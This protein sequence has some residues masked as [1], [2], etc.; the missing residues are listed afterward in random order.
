MGHP[1]RFPGINWTTPII[2][3]CEVCGKVIKSVAYYYIHVK[4]CLLKKLPKNF[5]AQYQNKDGKVRCIGCKKTFTSIGCI[6]AKVLK[7]SIRVVVCCRADPIKFLLDFYPKG[8]CIKLV[9]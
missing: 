8:C 4:A 7:L 2:R 1:V 3:T 6:Y 5:K 9:L